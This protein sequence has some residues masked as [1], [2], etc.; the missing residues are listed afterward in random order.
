MESGKIGDLFCL[1][2]RDSTMDSDIGS[3][4]GECTGN[5]TS[6][7]PARTCHKRDLAR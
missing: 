2:M 5:A 1:S 4:I 3:R 6:N 7:P